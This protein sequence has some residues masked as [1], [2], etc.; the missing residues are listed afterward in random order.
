MQSVQRNHIQ[1]KKNPPSNLKDHL[2]VKSRVVAVAKSLPS[3]KRPSMALPP[4]DLGRLC[5][6]TSPP[7][8][9]PFLICILRADHNVGTIEMKSN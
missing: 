3:Q 4:H 9:P 2:V 7:A 6:L 5:L 8:P 1:E